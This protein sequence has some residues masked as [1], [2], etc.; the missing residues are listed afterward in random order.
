VSRNLDADVI[1][2][3]AGVIGCIAARSLARDHDVLVLE[4]DSIAAGASG[5]AGASTFSSRF[6][7]DLPVVA[8]HINQWFRD[9]AESGRIDLMRSWDYEP[10][11]PEDAENISD[12]VER[13]A[14]QGYPVT[15]VSED[16]LAS[17]CPWIDL[18]EF[19][20]A[21]RHDDYAWVDPIE[22]TT[23]LAD[24]ARCDGATI[25]IGVE[26]TGLETEDDRVVGVETDTGVLTAE[27]VVT[28]AGWRTVD[29]LADTV[30]LPLQPYITQGCEL[31]VD[32]DI[33][34]ETFPAFRV[35]VQSGAGTIYSDGKETL[36]IRP[37][38]NGNL[39]VAGGHEAPDREE[40][41]YVAASDGTD[42]QD[43][44]VDFVRRTVPDLLTDVDELRVVDDW[45]GTGGGLTPDTRPIIDDS[46]SLYGLV[47][48]TGFR[49]GF[50][51]SPIA[52]Q[53][54]RSL[55]TGERCPFNLDVFA[56]DRF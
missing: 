21:I 52:A 18:T 44:F 41:D 37:K 51:Q 53:G 26:V 20:G 48:A 36:L 33:D 11:F 38:R 6:A 35:P 2:V 49:A 29:L 56:L 15:Y 45:A 32:R 24:G 17:R 34:P 16:E 19:G 13:M 10:V 12:R 14:K 5:L 54:V 46:A 47:V 30:S 28:A 7:S 9:Y 23:A 55:V 8:G 39:R 4:R 43:A 22:Y 3:G 1:I 31:E 25:R 42:A 50:I 40:Y 27:T